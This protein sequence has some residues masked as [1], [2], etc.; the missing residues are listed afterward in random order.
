MVQEVVL[1]AVIN[2]L[3]L[4]AFISIATH[5]HGHTNAKVSAVQSYAPYS[6][7]Y[8][9]TIGKICKTSTT[10]N[11]KKNYNKVRG[12]LHTGWS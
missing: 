7:F 6:C 8:Y 10:L 2:I 12:S 11:Y 4:A 3:L 9:D 1:S 5:T